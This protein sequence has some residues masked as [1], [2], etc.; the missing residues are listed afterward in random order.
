MCNI[1]YISTDKNSTDKNYMSHSIWG[2]ENSYTKQP[3][4]LQ[5]PSRVYN[6]IL[7]RRSQYPTRRYGIGKQIRSKIFKTTN[8]E[9]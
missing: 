9:K 4:A 5:S 6:K 2:I 8:T 1:V 3:T 7:S